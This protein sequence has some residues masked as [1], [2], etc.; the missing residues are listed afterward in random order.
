MK[1][2]YIFI[3]ITFFVLF[4]FFYIPTEQLYQSDILYQD[5]FDKIY[6]YKEMICGYILSTFKTPVIII[7]SFYF[8][9]I[10]RKNKR[11]IC[12]FYDIKKLIKKILFIGFIICTLYFLLITFNIDYDDL[13]LI[14]ANAIHIIISFFF[15]LLGIIVYRKDRRKIDE[16]WYIWVLTL[17]FCIFNSF[18]QLFILNNFYSISEI[19]SDIILVIFL[20]CI[21]IYIFIKREKSEKQ[22]IN[23]ELVLVEDTINKIEIEKILEISSKLINQNDY[24]SAISQLEKAVLL[25]SEKAMYQLANIYSEGKWV[26]ENISKAVE[27]YQSASER[28]HPEALY[29]LGICYLKGKGVEKNLQKGQD[30]LKRASILGSKEAS[31]F[32]IKTKKVGINY[33]LFLSFIMAI[34]NGIILCGYFYLWPVIIQEIHVS[35]YEKPFIP[36]DDFEGLYGTI[37]STIRYNYFYD[38]IG[39]LPVYFSI[40]IF[41]FFFIIGFLKMRS[42]YKEKEYSMTP[43]LFIFWIL[44]M[45]I[46]AIDGINTSLPSFSPFSMYIFSSIFLI[47]L[48]IYNYFLKIFKNNIEQ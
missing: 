30:L 14:N 21:Y 46:G 20:I 1:K 33:I 8:L 42:I 15:S 2:K 9:L 27:F 6:T 48:M 10:Y 40:F 34:I 38:S 12:D 4:V 24:N 29:E 43:I 36:K 18:L 35:F 11:K 17:T 16:L 19:M 37:A 47:C 31:D 28:N 45:I 32:L 41:I 3:I 25:G 39:I 26:N 5:K 23:N 22:Y 13:K 44:L 7:L